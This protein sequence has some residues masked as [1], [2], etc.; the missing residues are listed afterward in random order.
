MD[1]GSHLGDQRHA[2]DHH[3]RHPRRWPGHPQGT[4]PGAPPGG[5]AGLPVHL[6]IPA[7]VRPI[8]RVIAAVGIQIPKFGDSIRILC[9]G[10]R[11]IRMLSPNYPELRPELRVTSAIQPV[12][13]ERLHVRAWV[14][15]L[16]QRTAYCG[17]HPFTVR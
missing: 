10:K 7:R 15:R 4:Q 14:W 5:Q 8:H 12:K 13:A 6:Q 2:A 1:I 17:T 3:H 11:K 16:M 9:S